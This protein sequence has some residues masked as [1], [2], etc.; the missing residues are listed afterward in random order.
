MARLRFAAAQLNIVVG[1]LD[2][3]ADRILTAIAKAESD[4]C[5]LVA[6]PELAITGYPPEDLL[7]KPTFVDDNLAA[8]E[9]VAAG[10]GPI[11]AFVGFVDRRA[12]GT[13]AN[14]AAVLANGEVVGRYHKRRLPN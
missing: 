2:G 6:F 14:A 1:D 9:R 12:D 3:N 11:A 10:T 13:L 8:L 4:G 5:D 7:L